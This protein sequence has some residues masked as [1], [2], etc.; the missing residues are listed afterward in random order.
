MTT[1]QEVLLELEGD[2]LGHPYFVSGHALYAA[3][4]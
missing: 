4:A 2:Y 1:I 3:L